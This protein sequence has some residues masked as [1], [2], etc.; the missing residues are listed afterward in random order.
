MRVIGFTGGVGS[1]KSRL[2]AYIK[3]QYNCRVLLADEAA[4]LVKEPG[5]PCYEQLIRLLGEEILH[6]DGT[7]DKAKMAEKIFTDHALLLAVNG[8][9]HPAVKE[10]ILS[11]IAAEREA[12]IYDFFFLE[13]ALLIE[14]GYLK[15]VDEMWYIYADESVRKMRLMQSRGYTE[16]KIAA[17][18]QSQLS[19]EEFRKNCTVVID[20]S[21]SF[22]KTKRQIDKKLGEY[23]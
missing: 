23:L 8:I 9:I 13:A 14:E 5:Q 2:L 18:M 6:A 17:I 19:E 12:G 10:R 1:G 22:A 7:I 15:V 16:E 4:H 3:E 11:E 20:N 21:G